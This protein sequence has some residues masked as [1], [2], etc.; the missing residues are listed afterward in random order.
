M[1]NTT[2]LREKLEKVYPEGIYTFGRMGV[3]NQS[4]SPYRITEG[5][6]EFLISEI[7]AAEKAKEEHTAERIAH[8]AEMTNHHQFAKHIRSKFLTNP[9]R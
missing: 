5:M 4:A 8:D 3:A 6:L 9:E 1:T 2:E 7:E